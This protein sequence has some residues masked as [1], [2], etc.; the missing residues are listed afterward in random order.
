MIKVDLI[1]I[2]KDNYAYLL[3]A[4]NGDVAVIDPGEAVPIIQ[5]LEQRGLKLDY[6]LNTHHHGDH[7]AGNT[8]LVKKYGAKIV[9]PAKETDRIPHMDILLQEKDRFSFGGEEAEIFETPGHTRGHICF[10][11]SKSKLAFT[12]DTLFLMGC[13]RL[14]EG[15][16][17][18][19]WNS[20]Q[21]IMALPDDTNI[22]CGH[23]YTLALAQ[24]CLRAE[25][26]NIDLQKRVQ[27]VKELRKQNLPT[28]PATLD[29]EKKTNA[30][31]RAGSAEKFSEIRKLLD[32]G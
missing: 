6:I 8:E 1:P 29:L 3:Q 20:L 23:E 22:Y 9:G 5:A 25:P 28:I 21:K 31:L 26:D 16:A 17:A 27:K 24:F 7:I 11:F 18:Q 30:F 4:D 13:G 15:T 19:M 10:Y 12:G 32:G 14:F 2:L